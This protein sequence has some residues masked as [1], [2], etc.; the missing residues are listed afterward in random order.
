[1]LLSDP[2]YRPGNVFVPPEA[3]EGAAD[4]AGAEQ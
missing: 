4:E 3:M 1:M 2:F